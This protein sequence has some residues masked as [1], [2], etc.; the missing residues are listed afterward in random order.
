MMIMMIMMTMLSVMIMMAMVIVNY[1]NT[2]GPEA[3]WCSA[4]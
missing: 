3:L 1:S 2:W 4:I